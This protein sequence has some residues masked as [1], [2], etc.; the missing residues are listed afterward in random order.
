[1]APIVYVEGA[2]DNL[3]AFTRQKEDNTV[4]C[5]FNFSAEPA[6]LTITEREAGDYTCACGEK[7]SFAA[8][9]T[10]EL[11]AWDFKLLAR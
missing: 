6:T 5:V 11:G 3:F 7:M 10:M 2:S 1:M 9:D 8:G 4:F